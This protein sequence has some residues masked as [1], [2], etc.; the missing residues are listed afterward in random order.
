MKTVLRKREH[1]RKLFGKSRDLRTIIDSGSAFGR[2]HLAPIVRYLQGLICLLARVAFVLFITSSRNSGAI[3]SW[4]VH[5]QDRWVLAVIQ[6]L[7]P[8]E[9]LATYGQMYDMFED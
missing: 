2:Y 1:G 9:A 7:I 4:Q 5:E 3:H 8:Y 6:F